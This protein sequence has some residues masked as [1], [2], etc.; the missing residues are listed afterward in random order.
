[1]AKAA[2]QAI[3]YSH[4]LHELGHSIPITMRCDNTSSIAVAKNPILSERSKHI[5]ICYHFIRESVLTEKFELDYVDTA[6]N[7]ADIF[8]KSLYR[9]KH[10]KF[11]KLLGCTV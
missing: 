11:S 10:D 3:W 6:S 8:T 4:G 1:M 7:P 9:Q 2:R 5:D